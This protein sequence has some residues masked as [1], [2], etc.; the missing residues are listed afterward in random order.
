MTKKFLYI[1]T[2]AT[3]ICSC[4]KEIPAPAPVNPEDEIGVERDGK[5]T[6]GFNVDLGEEKTAGTKAL[7][8]TPTI[9]NIYVAVFDATGYKLSEYVKANPITPATTN[10]DKYQFTIQLKVS[11]KPRT[12]HFIANG[13][14]VLRFGTEQ[15][16]IGELYSMYNA[17]ESDEYSRK[18]AYWQRLEFTKIAP[19]PEGADDGSKDWQD[20][21]AMVTKLS[22]L[23]LIR[24]FS[25]V[26][27]S[28]ADAVTNFVIQG[29][30]FVNYP[31]RG[32]IAP[33]NRN[34]GKFGTDLSDLPGGTKRTKN[35]L[36]YDNMAGIEDPK[37]GNY[38]GFTLA[39]TNFITPD[40]SDESEMIAASDNTVSGYVYEREKALTSPMYLIVKGT[41]TDTEHIDHTSYY[42]I[43]MQDQN[44][45]HYAMLRNFNYNVQILSV[46]S[47]GYS[48]AAD[49]LAGVP[50]GDISM[51]IDFKDLPNISDG[52][53]RLTVN[54]TKLFVIPSDG[55]TG[56]VEI[57]YKYE[58]DITNHAD[59]GIGNEL[60]IEDPENPVKNRPY[61]TI[62]QDASGSTGDVIESLAYEYCYY[63]STDSKY[64]KVTINETGTK[65]STLIS[66]SEFDG[67]GHIIINSTEAG[68]TPKT[69]SITITGK[70]WADGRYR[71]ITRT[72]QLVLR[73]ALELSLSASP[74]TGTY[75]DDTDPEHPTYNAAY[76]LG[77][78]GQPVV[79]HIGI[80]QDLPSS[81]FPLYF[82]VSPRAKSLTPDNDHASEQELPVRYGTDATGHP[83]YWFEKAISWTEYEGNTNIVNGKKQFNVYFK[84]ILANNQTLIDISNDYFVPGTVAV[85]NYT[86]KTFSGLAFNGS[87]HKVAQSE[88]FSYTMSAVP[89]DGKVTIAMKG[90][91]PASMT[92][93]T[94]L[95]KDSEGY[96][97][98]EREVSGTS[99][100]FNVV[101]YQGGTVS[102]K[103]S[104][105]LF[106]D[107]TA[108]VTAI[109]PDIP[110]LYINADGSGSGTK[111]VSFTST[112]VNS[113][114]LVVGQKVTLSFYVLSTA[115]SSGDVVSITD[116]GGT[117]TTATGTGS[118]IDV[119]GNTFNKY[120]VTYTV[121]AGS[122]GISKGYDNQFK[123]Y[124]K[125]G[126]AEPVVKGSFTLPVYGIELGTE[127]TSAPFDTDKYYVIQNSSTSRYLYNTGSNN[128]TKILQNS[129]D[130]SSLMKING[131]EVST[132][133][134]STNYYLDFNYSRSGSGSKSSNYKYA[135]NPSLDNANTSSVPT[136]F[137]YS[138]QSGLGFALHQTFNERTRSGS[139]YPDI[140]VTRYMYDNNGTIAQNT[141]AAYWHI[142]PVTFVAP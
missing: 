10:E 142:Y 17:D 119:E 51:N 39:S 12:L 120:T 29:M 135:Y 46:S 48:S 44:G 43:A 59:T 92:G 86:P 70:K 30:W 56:S 141:T 93:F 5:V 107:A 75:T 16:V 122:E 49:A 2:L 111:L 74:N 126:S 96:W 105:Y 50:A 38:Q 139:S 21:N 73:D 15:E 133:S 138:Y 88:N 40:L 7:S 45:N 108:S 124:I 84:T 36:D 42:K 118:S 76:V 23:K 64:Y 123:V 128:A 60:V 14:E 54:A 67:N 1:L 91:E 106:T 71:T 13:P 102:I 4:V 114:N 6:L 104:A 87:T 103:L 113:G 78:T 94:F 110:V 34:T 52:N 47:A 100:N 68:A 115:V 55:N 31:D 132:V 9:Q 112:D 27:L 20:Y 3:L 37:Q 95:G 109:D 65:T 28:K 129:Y 89:A 131:G 41:Y 116:N 140:F 24:N 66:K 53:A 97:I 134:T 77:Q 101:P 62:T 127:L 83:T 26:T 121:P 58:P 18:D 130:F 117:R 11:D 136:N 85:V 99:D 57:L 8:E 19:R 63:N 22:D 82:K 125:V 72:I 79:V 35:Y 33:Y 98:Y 137:D 25:K 80:D 81:M 61:V 90:I 32:S 69:Q